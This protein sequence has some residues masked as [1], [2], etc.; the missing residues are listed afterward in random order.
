MREAWDLAASMPNITVGP[1]IAPGASVHTDAQ[2]LEFIR[3]AVQP[4]W[5]AS[6]TCRMGKKGDR[7]AVVDSKARIFGVEGLRVVD[8]SVFPVGLPGHLVASVY[9]LAEKIAG[10]ILGGG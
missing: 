4:I 1:E 10:D 7:G 9:A 5:H 6:S 2:I 8:A 3:G